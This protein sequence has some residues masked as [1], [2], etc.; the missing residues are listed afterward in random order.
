MADIYGEET[1]YFSNAGIR[2]YS[3]FEYLLDIIATHLNCY[4][5]DIFRNEDGIGVSGINLQDADDVKTVI[6]DIIKRHVP[7][8]LSIDDVT[9]GEGNVAITLSGSFGLQQVNLIINEDDK[10]SFTIQKIRN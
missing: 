8:T 3:Y 9:V 6:N 1:V 10:K 2:L 5:S 7:D 4:S